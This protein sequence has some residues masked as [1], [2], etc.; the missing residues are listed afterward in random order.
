MHSTSALLQASI[1]T[2]PFLYPAEETRNPGSRS[3]NEARLGARLGEG[4]IWRGGGRLGRI[5]GATRGHDLRWQMGRDDEK[6]KA[7]HIQHEAIRI[8]LLNRLSLLPHPTQENH[9]RNQQ[10]CR[11]VPRHHEVQHHPRGP[12]DP[13]HRL[14]A[15]EP[16]ARG[17]SSRRRR[18]QPARAPRLQG[19]WKSVVIPSPRH[20]T[21]STHFA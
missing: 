8:H 19:K 4:T 17:R 21:H 9:S 7:G 12:R 6:Y 1:S 11:P 16:R 3:T 14:R 20:L 15:R 10:P 5:E 13:L 18:R 2:C